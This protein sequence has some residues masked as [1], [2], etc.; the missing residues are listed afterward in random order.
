ML[1]MCLSH[2]CRNARA[3]LAEGFAH[4]QR[5]CV[6]HP[7]EK[8][9]AHLTVLLTGCRQC[10]VKELLAARL[11]WQAIDFHPRRRIWN[12]DWLNCGNEPASRA[13][14]LYALSSCLVAVAPAE[15]TVSAEVFELRNVSFVVSASAQ[16][17]AHSAVSAC[18]RDVCGAVVAFACKLST[19][20]TRIVGQRV[21][22]S[23]SSLCGQVGRIRVWLAIDCDLSTYVQW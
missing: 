23:D 1:N 6:W 19:E 7:F 4:G 10:A 16:T 11:H 13:T 20:T 15:P 5:T 14:P 12:R 8:P 3:N 22:S 21:V 9:S 17:S 2:C 18:S